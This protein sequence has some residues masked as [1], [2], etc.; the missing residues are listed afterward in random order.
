MLALMGS[1][2][3]RGLANQDS[4]A[5]VGVPRHAPKRSRYD[6]MRVTMRRPAGAARSE[7]R[8]HT[9]AGPAGPTQGA[10]IEVEEQAWLGI[11]I[12]T[13]LGYARQASELRVGSRIA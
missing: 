12:V 1:N 10:A 8:A 13:V 6:I 4:Q 7:M 9:L 11:P 5:L 3:E 2:R